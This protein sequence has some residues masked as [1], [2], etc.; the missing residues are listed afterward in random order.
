MGG[1][2]R[3]EGRE[4]KKIRGYI[5]VLS[6]LRFWLWSYTKMNGIMAEREA[7]ALRSSL[8]FPH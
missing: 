1:E 4:V 8:Q 5:T 6:C 3:G 2:L 7:L